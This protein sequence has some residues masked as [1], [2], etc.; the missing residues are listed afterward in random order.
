MAT[1]ENIII[2]SR[3][4]PP[5]AD[6]HYL[7]TEGLRYI[8][9]M[10]SGLWTDYNVH[11]PGVTM[12]EALCYAITELTYRTGFDLK[13]LL[14]NVDGSITQPFFTPREILTAAPLT[15]TDYRKL[16]IDIDGV[17]NAWVFPVNNLE[18]APAWIRAKG[19]TEVALYPDCKAETLSFEPTDHDPVSMRGL[20]HVRLDLDSTDE[21][22]DLNMGD[23]DFTLQ[24]KAISGAKITCLFP[25]VDQVDFMQLLTYGTRMPDKVEV[26]VTEHNGA[27]V[28]LRWKVYLE[29]KNTDNLTFTFQYET[30]V[31]IRV[32]VE[33]GETK[34]FEE[35]IKEELEVQS[36]QQ[37]IMTLYCQ[38]MQLTHNILKQVWA[39]L[40]SNRNLSEDWWTVDT[41]SATPVAF[42][43]DIDVL[44]ET[45]IDLVYAK[46]VTALEQYCNPP[47]NFYNLREMQAMQL[48][49]EKIFEGPVLKNGFLL[50]KDIARAEIRNKLLGSEV[51]EAIMKIEG[52]IAV[53]N[54]VMTAYDDAGRAVL[55]GQQWLLHLQTDHKPVADMER[56]KI[57]FYKNQVPFHINPLEAADTVLYLRGQS[58][59]AKISSSE[60]NFASP[61]GRYLELQQYSSL[62]H[63]LP[64]IYGTGP[65]GLPDAA[66]TEHKA[67]AKQLK[68]YLMFYD[69][70]LAGFF[71][72]LHHAKDL[73]SLDANITASYF[74]QFLQDWKDDPETGIHNIHTI[75]AN[76]AL[77]RQALELPVKEEP[78]TVTML[79]NQLVETQQ[80]RYDRRNRF[81]DHLIARFAET[82]N[83]YVLTRFASRS[84][85]G[86]EELIAD[87]IRF[88]KDYP[89]TSFGRGQGV[90]I[91]AGVWNTDNMSGLQRR[92]GRLS[93]INQ[94][95]YRS[96]FQFSAPV[97][98]EDSN[99]FFSFVIGDN[100][101]GSGGQYLKPEV[102]LGTE[103]EAWQVVNEIYKHMTIRELYTVVPRDGEFVI[104]LTIPESEVVAISPDVYST[105]AEAKAL[106]ELMLKKFQLPPDN[107][108]LH[109]IEHFML[110]PR[111]TPAVVEGIPTHALYNLMDVCLP[112][113]CTCCGDEDPYSFR[114][115]VVLPYWPERF[116]E[117]GY[118]MYFE[119]MV[120]MECPAHIHAKI[121]WVNYATRH[122]LES[123]HRQW[124]AALKDYHA[125]ITP[126]TKVQSRLMFASNQLV[127]VMKDL[128]SVYPEA[129]LHDCAEGTTNPVLLGQT[130][131][132]TF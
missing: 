101:D 83:D 79:R 71:A 72:Q 60:L 9:S 17:A 95:G 12:L 18:T 27:G 63:D 11:D 13:D 16:L 115:S 38:K 49:T 23:I 15:I 113:D 25:T 126:D 75:Y 1:E 56:S 44:P 104:K 54:L 31:A 69:Q 3:Q 110:R 70:L 48:S 46:L 100:V 58:R 112:D 26:Y 8:E 33:V 88:I 109:V 53:R 34:E 4:L 127:A 59:N 131:L 102:S 41:I 119:R 108:T 43:A 19:A 62:Q 20:Y 6:F 52:V 47:I 121:C 39:T 89:K 29:Y 66:S 80:Q 81:L 94:P 106:L 93:G 40:H 32:P 42:C 91:T 120:R 96:L 87:K 77:L 24:R 99:G 90:D 50:D 105:E 37:R 76:P 111:F 68:A 84:A 124:L 55:P 86:E 67:R 28:P 35:I 14:T 51:M 92:I 57:I 117:T 85:A 103:K 98:K 122:R 64:E 125:F 128:S 82:F 30:V 116:R 5:A 118:R 73:M 130:S 114:I 2:K 97:V 132:G 129:T 10:G 36:I 107:E 74:Q 123:A 22:G 7:R 78:L 21:Y 45:D 61:G 65:A